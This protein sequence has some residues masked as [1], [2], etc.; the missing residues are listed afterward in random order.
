MQRIGLSLASQLDA[1]PT[2]AFSQDPVARV[3]AIL[4]YSRA[5]TRDEVLEGLDETDAQFAAEVRRAIFTFAN[6]PERVSARDI[7]KVTRGVDQPVLVTA[8]AFCEGNPKMEKARE[9]I[10]ENMSKRMADALREEMGEAGK[11]KDDAGEEATN[12]VVAEIRRL[13]EAGELQLIAEEDA[14]AV[15]G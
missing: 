10:L 8:L 14:E 15:G 1:E 12:A 4:N 3:G 6:I 13:V 5:T 9:Y 11:V 2:S 7:P